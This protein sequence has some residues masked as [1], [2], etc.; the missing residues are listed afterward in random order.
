MSAYVEYTIPS[1]TTWRQALTTFA[2]MI[3]FSKATQR[4]TLTIDGKYYHVAELTS[5]SVSLSY[6]IISSGKNSLYVMVIRSNT[7]YFHQV[8]DGAYTDNSQATASG[9]LRL[10]Y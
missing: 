7:P 6:T 5:S 2:G 4:A 10:Y 3:D 8:V 1:N 9:K